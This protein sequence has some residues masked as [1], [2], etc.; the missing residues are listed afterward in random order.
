MWAEQGGSVPDEAQ[1]PTWD[2][3]RG[4][5]PSATANSKVRQSCRVVT[6]FPH[7]KEVKQLRAE[8]KLE[9]AEPCWGFRK[10]DLQEGI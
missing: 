2:S 3:K 7:E 8:E 5:C 1:H 9:A 6:Q 10:A 4:S